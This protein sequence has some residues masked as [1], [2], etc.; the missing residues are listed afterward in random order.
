MI[1]MTKAVLFDFDGTLVNTNE[2]IVN[3]FKH[4]F[5]KVLNIDVPKAQIVKYF[6]EPLTKTMERFSTDKV[7]EMLKT[8]R[9]FNEHGHDYMMEAFDGVSDTLLK[10]VKQHM[11]VGV[12]SSKRRVL[13]DKGLKMFDLYKYM[14]FIVTV[15]DTDKFKPCPEPALKAL[16]ILNM[17][18]CDTLFV[19]DSENDILCGKRA[20]CSTCVVTYSAIPTDYLMKFKPDYAID[21]MR[22]ILDIIKIK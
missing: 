22:E 1:K 3:S 18:A 8:Y 15:E 21:N 9:D 12:V 11:K 10:L 2:L 4:T 13:V 16:D 6:G 5:K 20:G 19:G 17:K 7:D 14:D